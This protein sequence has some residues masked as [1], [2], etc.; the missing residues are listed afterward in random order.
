[1]DEQSYYEHSLIGLDTISQY[2]EAS[3]M[4]NERTADATERIASSVS[5]FIKQYNKASSKKDTKGKSGKTTSIGGSVSDIVKA[6]KEFDGSAKEQGDNMINFFSRFHSDVVSKYD[7]KT[8]DGFGD[9]INM[10]AMTVTSIDSML[11]SASKITP[12]MAETLA[13]SVERILKG[14]DKI[15]PES[16][17]AFNTIVDTLSNNVLNLGQSLSKSI[18]YYVKAQV[19]VPLVTKTIKQLMDVGRNADITPQDAETVSR[20]IE[21]LASNVFVLGQSLARSSKYYKAAEPAIP[22]IGKV[23]TNLITTIYENLGGKDDLDRALLAAQTIEVLSRGVFSLAKSLAFSAPLMILAIPGA[24]AFR[25]VMKIISPALQQLSKVA[26]EIRDGSKA[27][28]GMALSIL[29]F[30]GSIVLSALTL[31]T[32]EGNDILRLT[33]LFGAMAVGALVF[34][35]IG[36]YAVPIIKGS[37]AVISMAASIWLFGL[38][39][40]SAT[41]NI[42]DL[43]KVGLLALELGGLALTYGIMGS[44]ATNILLG[45]LSVAAIGLSLML[46]SNPLKSIAGTLGESGDVL[47]KLPVLLTALG[48][49]YAAAGIP[50]VAGFILLGAGAM[51]AIGG[52]LILLATGLKKMT[53]IQMTAEDAKNIEYAISGTIKGFTNG[54]KGLSLKE[55]ITL[56]LKI[57]GVG[58]MGLSLRVFAGGIGKWKEEASDWGKKDTDQLIYTINSLSKAFAVAGSTEGQKKLFGF[59]VGKN[60]TER[61]IASTMKMGRN[62]RKLAKGISEWQEMDLSQEDMQVLSDNITRVLTTIPNIFSAIGKSQR[63]DSSNQMSVLGVSFGIPFTK[64]DVELGISS[65]MKMGNNLKN[66]ADGI[67]AWKDMPLTPEVMQTITDNITRVLTTIPN[68]FAAIGKSQREDSANQ[69]SVLGVSFGIPFTKTD[70]EL[71]ISSTM[72]MGTNLKTLADGVFA[73]KEGGKGGFKSE[74]LPKIQENILT[75][76]SSIPSAFAAIGKEDRETTK[77]ILW[78]KKGDVERGV[79]LFK[80]I[81]PTIKFV[82]DLVMGFKDVPDVTTHAENIGKSVSTILMHVASGLEH[83]DDSKIKI[84]KDLPKPLGEL[85]KVFKE[86][87][88][89]FKDFMNMDFV[90]VEEAAVLALKLNRIQKGLEY[91]DTTVETEGVGETKSIETKPKK[92]K[93]KSAAEIRKEAENQIMSQ[94][95]EVMNNMQQTM[96]MNTAAITEMKDQMLSGVLKTKEV[97]NDF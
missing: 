92:N 80:T 35:A 94:L 18:P 6:V 68:I 57:A 39:I 3:S 77:G 2:A 48:V 83:Y 22:V 50:V 67:S 26:P 47:W 52:S 12:T 58:A 96:M 76:L 97:S 16:A 84:L 1:M 89:I 17:Q 10:L 61:G 53:E 60:D 87:G 20:I 70:V 95:L 23:I 51:A 33:A 21:T 42:P 46:L 71:G 86:W 28:R 66:L 55:A 11:K 91:E 65:T 27:L 82:A 40:K 81:G 62:L 8:T 56:P 29:L 54:F 88:E 24:A 85:T 25:V 14:F 15:T 49:T 36:N 43:G 73:W 69:V 41:E 78:W 34:Y 90:K 63:E 75:V 44:F 79:D 59:K 30:S 64:T 4:S 9:T 32:L 74:D 93:E 5:D 13:S 37:I 45:A 38:G 31:R 72:E 7:E 19:A